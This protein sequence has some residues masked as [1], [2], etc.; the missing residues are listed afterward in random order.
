MSA[1]W[2]QMECSV[3]TCSD[4]GL[5]GTTKIEA[6]KAAYTAGDTV[7]YSIPRVPQ[8][9]YN[10]TKTVLE[11]NF[12]CISEM[13]ALFRNPMIGAIVGKGKPSTILSMEEGMIVIK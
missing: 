7:R 3:I 9:R 11:F 12:M 5:T 2:G 10:W 6:D 13:L 4:P 8:P 1:I